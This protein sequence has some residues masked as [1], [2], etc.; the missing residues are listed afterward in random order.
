LVINTIKIGVNAMSIL[1]LDDEQRE[2]MREIAK[3]AQLRREQMEDLEKAIKTKLESEI[4][5]LRSTLL[6]NYKAL[7][8]EEDIIEI[9]RQLVNDASGKAQQAADDRIMRHYR[10]TMNTNMYWGHF[11]NSFGIAGWLQRL[12]K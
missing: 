1:G 2:R 5:S 7:D 11:I 9:Q 6:R 3:E 8:F 10:M 12:F 4:D